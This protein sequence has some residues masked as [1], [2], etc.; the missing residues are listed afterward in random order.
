VSGV[1][2][3]VLAYIETSLRAGFSSFQPYFEF[4]PIGEI[5]PNNRGYWGKFGVNIG[6]SDRDY[7]GGLELSIV[8]SIEIN[9]FVHMASIGTPQ[10]KKSKALANTPQ[11]KNSNGR[12]QLVFTSHEVRQYIQAHKPEG[13]RNREKCELVARV[14]WDDF[15][16]GCL[17]T[18]WAKYEEILWGRNPIS[19][20]VS[21]AKDI[22][23]RELWDKY[24]NF[25]RP[26]LSPSTIAKDFDR[27]AKHIDGFPV[28]NLTDAVAVRDYLNAKTTPNTTKRILTQLGAACD[29][30][31]KS[32]IIAVN[33]FLGMAADI[34]L[35]KGSGDEADINPFSPEERDRIIEYLRSNNNRYASLVE[36]LFRTGCRPSEAIGLRWKDISPNYETITFEQVVVD[37][38]DGRVI[39]QGLKTQDRRVFP[40]GDGL[41]SFL[42][43]IKPEYKDLEQLV[44]KPQKGKFEDFLISPLNCKTPQI[45]ILEGFAWSGFRL[46]KIEVARGGTSIASNTCC[47]YTNKYNHPWKTKQYPTG[48]V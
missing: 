44:F 25:K 43:S 7:S 39:K 33:P 36:F 22:T 45:S 47:I 11:V 14:M 24:T 46:K 30:G 32:K 8:D 41:K 9:S 3:P 5:Y 35:P 31:I 26:H 40:C 27:V 28:S 2:I 4:C 18:S 42:Q 21:T 1:Q 38:E 13:K 48:V 10:T 34:K 15:E 12:L 23:I 6:I 17:D 37:S 19:E 20:R 16:S 29:W